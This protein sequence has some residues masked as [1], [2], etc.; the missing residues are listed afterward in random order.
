MNKIKM[1]IVA[2]IPYTGEYDIK[3]VAPCIETIEFRFGHKTIPFGFDDWECEIDKNLDSVIIGWQSGKSFLKS[4]GISE[5]YRDDILDVGIDPDKI[6]AEFLS[7]PDAIVNIHTDI[8]AKNYGGDFIDIGHDLSIEAITFVDENHT[9]YSV[10][11]DKISQFNKKDYV[12]PIELVYKYVPYNNVVSIIDYSKT[13][14]DGI[15]ISRY[16]GN[17][18]VEEGTYYPS[19]R[20]L[21]VSSAETLEFGGH[22]IKY[23]IIKN[24]EE[25][26]YRT[27]ARILV[28]V[29]N[30]STD[31]NVD[32]SDQIIT[33]I[34]EYFPDGVRIEMSFG[35][36]KDRILNTFISPSDHISIVGADPKSIK[37]VNLLCE[38]DK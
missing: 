38:E 17:F 23:Y 27:V 11:R 10:S 1:Y 7:K 19:V 9:A 34:V 30:L 33:R 15:A 8:T 31:S 28:F 18:T 6:T 3:S 20:Q 14:D 24:N 32:K 5:V 12:E 36:Y 26:D 37:L 25:I 35:T 13:N 21:V 22:D 29:E 4:D 2:T 16:G